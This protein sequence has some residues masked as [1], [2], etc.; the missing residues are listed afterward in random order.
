M[1]APAQNP[2]PLPVI[3]RHLTESS[4]ERDSSDCLRSRAIAEFIALSASGR[5]SVSTATGPSLEM[6]IV[7]YSMPVRR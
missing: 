2:F 5:F 1:S 6:P 3:T 7:W 4:F